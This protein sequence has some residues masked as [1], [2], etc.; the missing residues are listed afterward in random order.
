MFAD[1]KYLEQ[2]FQDWKIDPDSVDRSWSNYFESTETIRPICDSLGGINET[3]PSLDL[4]ASYL[5]IRKFF[6]EKGY[7][8][9][10]LLCVMEDPWALKRRAIFEEELSLLRPMLSR[11]AL[12]E[13]KKMRAIYSSIIAFEPPRDSQEANWFYDRLETEIP[14]PKMPSMT[15]YQHLVRANYFEQFLQQHFVGQKRFSLEGEEVLIPALEAIIDL[16]ASVQGRHV[17]LGMAHRGRLN[18]L[19]HCLGKSYD[20]IIREFDEQMEL[21]PED[22]GDVKYHRGHASMRH[23]SG[24]DVFMQLLAN[25][26]HLE[27]VNAAVMGFSRAMQKSLSPQQVLPILLHGDGAFSGQGVVYES[28]QLSGLAGYT[29][30]GVIHIILNNQVAF[31]TSTEESRSS[32]FCTDIAKTFG[33]PVLHVSIDDPQACVY[34]AELAFE[35][36][37]R[38]GKDILIDLI[39]YRRWG[40]NE[41]DEPRYTQ[42]TFYEKI[43]AVESIAYRYAHAKGI[44]VESVKQLQNLVHQELQEALVKAKECIRVESL[45]S[46]VEGLAMDTQ[47]RVLRWQ[48][49]MREVQ[50][51]IN[52][53]VLVQLIEKTFEIPPSLHVHKKLRSLYA[54]HKEQCLNKKELNWACAELLAYASILQDGHSVRLSG[55]DSVRGTFSHRHIG[56]YSPDEKNYHLPV[57]SLEQHEAKFEAINSPL[58]EFAVLGFEYGYSL[59]TSADLIIWEA[60]FGDFANGAQVLIDQFL[61]AGGSK[62]GACSRLTLYLPHGFEGQ[63]PEHSSARIERFLSLSAEGNWCVANVTTPAQLFH[64]LRRQV[65]QHLSR[66]LIL[67]TPKGLL[68]HPACRSSCDN[69]TQGKFQEMI[70]ETPLQAPQVLIMV[71]GRFYYELQE[72]LK[73]EPHVA[74]LR[75]EQLYPFDMQMWQAHIQNMKE[76]TRVIWVQEEPINM[77][78]AHWV[79][80]QVKPIC[81]KLG[82]EWLMIGR[83]EANCIATGY[84]KRHS[85]EQARLLQELIDQ[86]PKPS[87]HTAAA[88]TKSNQGT[89]S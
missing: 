16:F 49:Q 63:G 3:K 57:R 72:K 33:Y 50:T 22:M 70:F 18:V 53:D 20:L 32:L 83:A 25:P 64:L 37:Q 36:R 54:L 13:E 19:A 88:A 27:S 31:T 68:R 51:A 44:E 89:F 14:S 28:L 82:L 24:H 76:L 48:D 15:I 26:S 85:L 1:A 67:F 6:R 34:C 80:A 87:K 59:A 40:H 60:Q 29:C 46:P 65:L 77:G 73:L 61:A 11:K 2:L 75:L 12:D 7:L 23:I 84:P 45:K 17:V 8:G 5:L 86:L 39:G 21:S 43:D 79:R 66:P 42:P 74:W 55:Q 38:F 52:P 35:Y 71:S 69:I 41:A 81:E 4:E 62:W 30:S 9:A 47:A 10:P 56:L 58:S 78:A